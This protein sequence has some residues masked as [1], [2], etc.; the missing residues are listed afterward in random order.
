[1]KN[2]ILQQDLLLYLISYDEAVIAISLEAIAPG[3][4]EDLI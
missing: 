1:M 2:V 3:A 4:F